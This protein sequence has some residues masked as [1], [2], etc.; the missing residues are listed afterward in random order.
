MVPQRVSLVTLGVRDVAAAT[1]F[2][3]AL[4]WVKSSASQDEVTFM[5][6]SGSILALWG[7]NDLAE[8]AHVSSA[9]TGFRGF[10]LAMNLGSE[11][12]V[13]AVYEEW[14]AAGAT[15]LKR[16]ERVVWGG[17]SSYVADPEG[18][19]WELAYNPYWP[20]GEDGRVQLP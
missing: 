2:Y 3:E 6:T 20:I 15:E 11:A 4:G 13:D 12:E 16:P 1:R 10:G 14:L 9:G 17:Y 8:D 5:Q 18:N 19:I 7:W